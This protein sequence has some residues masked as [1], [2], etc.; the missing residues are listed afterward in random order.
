[1]D[2]GAAGT[3]TLDRGRADAARA[4]RDQRDASLE[5]VV[6]A[7]GAFLYG[8]GVRYPL[9]NRQR[10]DEVRTPGGLSL[11]E[12]DLHGERVSRDELRATPE[13]LRLQA[14]VAEDAGRRELGANL[15]RAAELAAVPD[16]TGA[17]RLHRP[18]ASALERRRAR[19]LGGAA[20]GDRRRR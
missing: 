20:R 7:H 2:V 17:R 12:L 6:V 19:V 11:D 1:M 3:Q 13:T 4:A 15:R 5:V 9:R 10:R 14:E 16:E 18:P 8:H